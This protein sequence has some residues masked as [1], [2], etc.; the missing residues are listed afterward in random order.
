MDHKGPVRRGHPWRLR[1]LA[2]PPVFD[3]KP[4]SHPCSRTSSLAGVTFAMACGAFRRRPGRPS[5]SPQ[6][7]VTRLLRLPRRPKPPRSCP[8]PRRRLGRERRRCVF[9]HP[10]KRRAMP[11]R[12]RAWETSAPVSPTPDLGPV[13]PIWPTVR[14]P[15]RSR[16][17]RSASDAP[18]FGFAPGLGSSAPVSRVPGFM[19]RL[20]PDNRNTKVGPGDRILCTDQRFAHTFPVSSPQICAQFAGARSDGRR[21]SQDL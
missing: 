20:A 9:A 2:V 8:A 16:C 7:T 11:A 15:G 1:N 18:P 6:P 5:P 17:L 13:P 3:D 4:P 12:T 14:F 19:L 21:E 10:P